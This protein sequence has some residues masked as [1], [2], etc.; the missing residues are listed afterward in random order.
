M[1]LDEAD[2]YVH[3]RGDNMH[4]NA[5]VGVFLRIL[6]YQN[7]VLFMTTNRPDDVDDAIASR[8]IAR[9]PF[10]VP[11][12]DEQI[13][14]WRILAAGSQANISEATIKAVA[15]ANPALSGRDVKNLLKLAMLING[16]EPISPSTIDFVK[17]FKPTTAIT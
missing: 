5:I 14:I 11:S 4:Q 8:C 10:R 1:L 17:Q 15:I 9:I 3:Q 2:V 6:E 7:A 12:T 13:R 16:T